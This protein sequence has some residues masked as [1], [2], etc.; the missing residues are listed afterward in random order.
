MFKKSAMKKN[1]SFKLYSFGRLNRSIT[2]NSSSQKFS[3][4]G[5]NI[6]KKAVITYMALY[7]LMI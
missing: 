4:I 6:I 2:K 7:V 3:E 5:S 1:I